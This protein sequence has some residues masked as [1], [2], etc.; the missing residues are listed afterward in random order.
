[1]AGASGAH[2]SGLAF[3]QSEYESALKVLR[4]VVGATQEERCTLHEGAPREGLEL[5][6]HAAAHAQ[7]HQSTLRIAENDPAE[8]EKYRKEKWRKEQMRRQ[9]STS[10]QMGGCL[11][12]SASLTSND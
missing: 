9:G 6:K 4:A 12:H 5:A 7:A 11:D 3:S 1:M 2:D 10:I 8:V